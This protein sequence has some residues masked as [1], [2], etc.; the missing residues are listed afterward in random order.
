[1]PIKVAIGTREFKTKTEAVK[2]FT[3]MLARYDNGQG[4]TGT[5]LDDLNSLIEKHPRFEE[6]IG[7]GI[8]RIFADWIQHG[9][10]CF[11][12]ERSDGTKEDFSFRKCIDAASEDS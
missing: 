11:W 10:R 9:A 5:D 6:K 8:K 1:M 7:N 3:D 2:H 12:I 4:V